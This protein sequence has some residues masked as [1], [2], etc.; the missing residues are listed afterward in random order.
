MKEEELLLARQPIFDTELNVHAYELL[1]RSDAGDRGDDLDADQATSVVLLNAFS[2]LGIENI[3]GHHQAFINFP[4]N[5][6]LSTPPFSPEDVVIE[7]LETVTPEPEILNALQALKQRG[8][9]IALD[10]FVYREDL[11]PL[12]ELA[13]IVKVDVL[14]LSETEI[15]QQVT[16]LRAFNVKLLAEKVE[17]QTMFDFCQ[18]L[19]F[20]YFQGY[21]LSKPRNFSGRVIPPNK[22]IVMELLAELQKPDITPEDLLDVIS[23]DPSLGYK[24]LRIIN[25]AAYRRPQEIE[26]LHRAILLLGPMVIK[27]WASMLALSNLSDKPHA[28]R[29]QTMLRAKVCELMGNNIS[30][31]VAD[32]CFTVGMF[33]TLDAYFDTD[34]TELLDMVSVSDEIKQALLQHEGIAGHILAA[35]VAYEKG[36]WGNIPW[37]ELRQHGLSVR[38]AK[39]A[40]IDALAWAHQNQS[41]I[42]TDLDSSTETAA[43]HG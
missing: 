6:I 33:S 14:E 18:A 8:F 39:T 11:K 42:Y 9:T 7:V 35:V 16:Q 27:H 26:S 12:V 17:T 31:S 19:G 24:M 20:D 25:S 29:E 40:Y 43:P 34:M 1:F 4:H 13:D 36:K 41:A 15:E 23:K 22:L 5:L 32:Q 21:F 2:E 10:D 30:T 28:L 3:T 37:S 38:D